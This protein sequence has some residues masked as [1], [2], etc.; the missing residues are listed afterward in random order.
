[1][2]N[3]EQANHDQRKESS[4]GKE[5]LKD[6][7]KININISQPEQKKILLKIKKEKCL[8]MNILIH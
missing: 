7:Q 1:M 4:L 6:D 8:T 5:E 2:E 3:Q